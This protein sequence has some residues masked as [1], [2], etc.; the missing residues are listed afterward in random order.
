MNEETERIKRVYLVFLQEAKRCDDTTCPKAADAIL[1]FEKSMGYKSFK[2]FHT[3]QA[4]TFKAKLNAE[5]SAQ[6]DKPLSKATISGI[7]RANKSFFQWRAGQPGYKSRIGHADAECFN[8]NAKDAR[9]A[10]AR[11]ETRYPT[12]AQCRAV[13]DAMP[14][15]TEIERRN[16][17]LFACLMITGARDGALASFKLKHVE[18]IEGSIFQDARE[19]RT[20]AAKTF[21]TFFVPV[22]PVC[23]ANF[24]TWVR[25]LRDDL[26]FGHDDPLF[27]PPQMGHP[28]RRFAVIG[29]KRACGEQ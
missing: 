1:R 13:F 14:D 8:Q 15:G 17:A 28:D 27:P 21:T 2:R 10:H 29:F 18:L 22:D 24:E 26:L 5:V 3:D 7:L 4:R 6:S 20:K 16:R 11:R 25:H 23:R 9:V 12:L 19:V